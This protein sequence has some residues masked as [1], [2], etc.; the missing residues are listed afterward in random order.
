MPET[1][2]G[3]EIYSSA[4]GGTPSFISSSMLMSGVILNS[5]Y[6]MYVAEGGIASVTELTNGGAMY[7]TDGGVANEAVLDPGGRAFIS[8]GGIISGTIISGGESLNPATL[9]VSKGGVAINTVVSSQGIMYVYYSGLAREATVEN[10]A[11]MY[12]Y[13]SGIASDVTVQSGGGIHISSFAEL[14]NIEISSGGSANCMRLLTPQTLNGEF[15]VSSA[16]LLTNGYI[17]RGQSVTDV[18]IGGTSRGSLS[19]FLGAEVNS[20]KLLKNGG[21]QISGGATANFTTISSGGSL[22]LR[23]VVISGV[24]VSAGLANSTT[25]CSGGQ[26]QVSAG[27]MAHD[28]AVSSGGTMVVSSGGIIRGELRMEQGASVSLSPGGTLD[29]F[30]AERSLEDDWIVND[31]SLVSGTPTYT[32]TVADDQA[33]GVYRLAQGAAD[34]A[35]SIAIGDGDAV[36]GELTVGGEEV[37]VG[38]GKYSLLLNE[39][40]LT[41]SVRDGVP[42]A[43]PVATADK[44]D[45]TNGDVTVTATFAED[46]VLNEYSVN[47]GTDWQVYLAGLT[48][49]ENGSVSFR[50]TDANDNV[51]DVTVFAVSNIDK[52]AP[53]LSI[54][55]IPDHWVYQD[56]V[57][58]VH[59]WDEASGVAD[60]EY[61]IDHGEWTICGGTVVVTE[62]ASI[63]VRAVDYAGNI[64]DCEVTVDQID[65]TPTVDDD[66]VQDVYTGGTRNLMT[67]GTI[68]GA[69]VG[70]VNPADGTDIRTAI[71]GGSVG[72]AVI[73]G[74]LVNGGTVA[75][76]GSVTLD[77]SGD[78]DVV[79]G[80][81]NGGMLYTAGYAYG[82]TG[83]TTTDTTPT[84]QVEKSELNLSD[85]STPV[86]NLYSGAHAR[87][88]AYTVVDA[89]EITVTGGSYGRIYGGG[90]AEKYGLSEV[91][92]SLITVSGGS[93]EYLYAGGGNAEDGTTV[94]GNVNI[95]FSGGTVDYAFLAGKNLYCTVGTVT[96]TVRGEEKHMIRVSGDNAC[97]RANQS[98]SMLVLETDL[99]VDYL[100]HVDVI[101][102][103]EGCT[104]AVSRQ[105]WYETASALRIDFDLDG[106]LDTDWT[107]MSGVGMAEYRLATYTIGGGS[108][109]YTYDESSGKLVNDMEESGYGLDFSEANKV[110]FVTIA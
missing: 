57:L 5:N 32:V 28:T 38:S 88:G 96:M 22:I 20:A 3:V 8:S 43:A 79:G 52:V 60:V 48:F 61:S 94:T 35:G 2:S 25:L 36:C 90:W 69:F 27:G 53:T 21:L 46:S 26:L 68:H 1:T 50:S 56:V 34:F 77:L 15:N 4:K 31:L 73:G 74:A 12:I 99:N 87:K 29:F 58:T 7:V 93:V 106:D 98:V 85:G 37:R 10:G 14:T 9:K 66:T 100:D 59:A 110:K 91:G 92:T 45:W 13:T 39:G 104:L 72:D 65:R 64:A 107:A 71:I 44:V 70:M 23:G 24:L 109:I 17:Y 63:S 6:Q 33:W 89:T 40:D 51:S 41:L 101:R 83:G 30:V 78:L 75:S 49:S 62:N 97:G 82:V 55:G 81:A 105:L 11:S 42:P 47:G 76:I 95:D 102:I 16:T 108:T 86:Q 67:G 18:E 103:A 19:A 80:T 84:L 54:D